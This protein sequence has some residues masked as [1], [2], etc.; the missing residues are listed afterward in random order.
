MLKTFKE[1]LLITAAAVLETVLP[2]GCSLGTRASDSLMRL[3][4]RVWDNVQKS[5][6]EVIVRAYMDKSPEV[7]IQVQV[8]S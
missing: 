8:T 6:M 1:G 2:G 4:F 7:G 5:G 3:N